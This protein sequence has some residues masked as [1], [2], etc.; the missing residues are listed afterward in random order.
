MFF[1]ILNCDVFWLAKIF[2]QPWKNKN[3]N[4]RQKNNNRPDMTK[5]ERCQVV[6]HFVYLGVLITNEG[7]CT[8]KNETQE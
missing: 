4:C 1:K 8:Q 2:I 6:H 7:V 5:V 3:H